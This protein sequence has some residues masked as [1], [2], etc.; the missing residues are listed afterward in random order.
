MIEV[1]PARSWLRWRVVGSTVAVTLVAMAALTILVQAVLATAVTSD[2]R[3][4]LRARADAVASTITVRDGRIV[5]RETPTDTL[6]RT[7]WIYDDAGRLVEGPAGSSALQAA[8]RSLAVGLTGAR[9]PRTVDVADS[10]LL[11]RAVTV[12]SGDRAVV[13]VAES[14]VPYERTERYALIVGLVLGSIV[15][16]GSAAVAW[17]SI[18]RALE[19]VAAMA[20]RARE[21][22]EHDLD[23]RFDLGPPQDEITALGQTLDGLLARVAEVIRSEQRLSQEMA[24]EL[25]T[26]LT[27]VRAEAE[28]AQLE[29]DLSDR[30]C[31]SLAR[32]VDASDGMAA[33]IATLM[34]LARSA[35]S[36]GR[37]QVGS[38]LAS[39][40]DGWG[41][42]APVVV[43]PVPDQL[44]V[45]APAELVE[46]A[47]SPLVENAVRHAR[48]RVDL[49]VEL[50]LH[51]VLVHVRDDGP[52]TGDGDLE[53]LFRPGARSSASEGAGLGLALARRVARSAG[54]DVTAVSSDDGGHFVLSLPQA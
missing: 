1:V 30:T 14:L 44:A 42:R 54:G 41:E 26:P 46:R 37:A 22:S 5:A 6:D 53:E 11:A 15:V 27:A 25:R 35:G 36:P 39:V 24:H 3:G 21:W 48:T 28:L 20:A 18:H 45:A 12:R 33:A 32:I 8:A 17:W 10:R 50:A 16:V 49:V 2:V 7:A 9:S 47:L 13:V 23:R 52:G 51:S 19:P 31:E 43:G 34:A 40:A 29:P 38:L 4:V